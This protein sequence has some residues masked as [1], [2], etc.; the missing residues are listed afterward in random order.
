LES[1]EWYVNC[2]I[3]I[4]IFFAIEIV[5]NF[6]SSYLDDACDVIDDRKMIFNQYFYGWFT[7][8]F[9]SILPLEVVLLAI[10]KNSASADD[11]AGDA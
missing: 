10:A 4:D 3:A 5:L 6:N 9:V 1:L 7:V 2:G 11:A 8:D